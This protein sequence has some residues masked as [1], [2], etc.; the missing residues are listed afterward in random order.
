MHAVVTAYAVVAA[1]ANASKPAL[2]DL[3]SHM[4]L[5]HLHKH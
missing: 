5:V 3:R 4:M 2:W 1:Y